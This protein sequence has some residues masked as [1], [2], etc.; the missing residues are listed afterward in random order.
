MLDK[1]AAQPS[2]DGKY[3]TRQVSFPSFYL[4]P[5]Q[6]VSQLLGLPDNF[7]K[8]IPLM[9]S[10]YGKELTITS[11]RAKVLNGGI[12]K[13]S[14]SKLIDWLNQLPI[15]FTKIA[16]P[17]LLRKSFKA[18]RVSSNSG[19]WHSVLHGTKASNNEYELG[20]LFDFLEK[21]ADDDY[22]MLSSYKKKVKQGIIN[23]DTPI[24]IWAHQLPTWSQSS[25]I[26]TQYFIDYSEWFHLY[27]SDQSEAKKQINKC[28]PAVI[29]MRFDFYLSAIAN[30]EI[31][32]ALY[33]QHNGENI[34]WDT[35]E[36]FMP[37]VIATC[38]VSE[39]PCYC[40][41]AMLKQFKNTLSANGL[42]LKW[43]EL[44][45][46]IDIKESGEGENGVL[47]EDKQYKQLKDWRNNKNMP[48]DKKFRAF[49]ESAVEPLGHY[50]IEHILIYARISR[51]IDRLVSLVSEELKSEH[52]LLALQGVLARYPEYLSHYK[53]L[54]ILK[55][56]TAT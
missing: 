15:P 54:L 9:E 3:A 48:S 36:G 40:F 35:F 25:L 28:F 5:P 41:G 31:G 2:D 19:I 20:E 50:N 45:A 11:S 30:Y 4:P 12:G 23:K 42:E 16:S 13:P 26:P 6:D 10:L 37:S 22:L 39:E 47:R 51:G 32:L 21:R 34:E 8:M 27:S 29:A 55:Q 44:A 17:S 46:Y 18:A 24:D 38:A 14:F 52:T 53:K 7:R 1:N 49:V 33:Q 43:R 56:Q